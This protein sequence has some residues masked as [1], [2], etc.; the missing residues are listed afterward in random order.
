MNKNQCGSLNP[1]WKGG[2]IKKDGYVMVYAPEHLNANERGYVYEHRL[3]ISGL[4]NRALYP[5]EDVHHIDENRSNNDPSNLMLIRHGDHMVLHNTGS[6]LF[7]DIEL[8][9]IKH[10]YKKGESASSLGKQYN[11]TPNTILYWLKKMDIEIKSQGFYAKNRIGRSKLTDDQWEEL[12]ADYASGIFFI[13][14]LVKKYGI[15]QAMIPRGLKAR[16][17]KIRQHGGGRKP[18]KKLAI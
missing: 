17:Y 5:D 6:K 1:N 10:E 16:G 12:Y 15:S 13:K 7:T 14:D 18:K 3:V 9:N 8:A 11:T 2:R 4:I